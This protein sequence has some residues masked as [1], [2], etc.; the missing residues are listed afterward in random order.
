MGFSKDIEDLQRRAKEAGAARTTTA[1]RT[2]EAVP[3]LASPAA[4]GT[5]DTDD[6][7]VATPEE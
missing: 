5:G 1:P 4:V 3:L 6:P 7:D 2:Q